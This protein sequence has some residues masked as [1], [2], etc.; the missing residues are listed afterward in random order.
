[1]SDAEVVAFLT[2]QRTLLCATNGPRGWPH[3]MPLWYVLR[4]A[5]GDP[6]QMWAWTYAASQKAVNIARDP[7]A[8]LHVEAG[9]A[10]GELRGVMVQADVVVHG[11]T[12]T[13]AQL[14]RDVFARCAGTPGGQLDGAT[15]QL[16]ERQAPKRVALQFVARRRASFDH[17][18]LP[19]GNGT[20]TGGGKGDR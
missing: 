3:V 10:Y 15:L 11:D 20:T 18:K 6:A 4:P 19:G 12:A 13:V 5:D 2:E 8:T 17:R 1:M 16:I 9:E 7:R 14:G